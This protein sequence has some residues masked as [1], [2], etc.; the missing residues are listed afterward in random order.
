MH[1]AG[2]KDSI[3]VSPLLKPTR[4]EWIV[5]L[6][7]DRTNGQLDC[8][9]A[10]NGNTGCGV[11]YPTLDSYGPPLNRIGGGWFAVERNDEFIKVWFWPRNSGSVPPDVRD[12]GVAIVTDNW[13]SSISLE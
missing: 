13:V 7:L 2:C 6:T 11:T 1:D 8:D 12:G 9:A 4:H 10:V 3:W 5:V